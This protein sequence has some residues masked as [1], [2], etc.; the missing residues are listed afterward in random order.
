MKT[1]IGVSLL[2]LLLALTCLT[3]CGGDITDRAQSA[4][5]VGRT[6]PTFT[7][8]ANGDFTVLQF[9]D[10]HLISGTTGKDEK[11]LAAMRTQIETQ[12][13]DMVVIS[14]D[15]I[16]GNNADPRFNKLAALETVGSLF[17]ELGQY[18]AYVPGNNDGEKNGSTEDVV[19]VL[20]TYNHCIVADEENLTGATQ[21]VVDLLRADGTLAHSLIFMDSLARDANNDYDYMKDDQVQW[22]SRTIVEKQ[23]ANPNV[24]VSLFFHM[25]TPNFALSG[26][27]GTPYSEEIAPVPADF[28]TGIDGNDALDDALADAGCVGLVSIGHIHPETNYVSFYNKTYYQVVRSSG[29]SITDAPGCSLVTIHTN[30]EATKDMYD[31]TEIAF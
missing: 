29:Y 7:V 27:N 13:P 25:N 23:S 4:S 3:A 8:D 19:A 24:T 20:S 16:E 28:Y 22:A 21:Y 6:V 5:V 26:Q 9:T 15:M 10:T 14:G 18:W 2:A 31:F 30:A 17:E 1:K 11:T 12:K